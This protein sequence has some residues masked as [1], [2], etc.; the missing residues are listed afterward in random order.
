MVFSILLSCRSGT[1]DNNQQA[2]KYIKEQN[3]E[4]A[5]KL[6]DEAIENDPDDPLGYI[7]FGNLLLHMNDF[8]RAKRFFKKAIELEDR[9]ATAYYS[10]GNLYFQDRKSTRLNSS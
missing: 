7:N 5:A 1:M 3:F 4:K 9:M 6:L 2:L 8:E 10:L